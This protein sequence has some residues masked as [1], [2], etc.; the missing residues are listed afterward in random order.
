MFSETFESK[1]PSRDQFLVQKQ[2]H[3]SQYSPRV[4]TAPQVFSGHTQG[5]IITKPRLPEPKLSPV[6][7]RDFRAHT[8]QVW[9]IG[10]VR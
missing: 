5:N 10:D 8:A 9:H 3:C 7:S 4:I 6:I 1:A 2:S